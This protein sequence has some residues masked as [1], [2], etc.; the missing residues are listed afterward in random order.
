M[1]NDIDKVS[2]V[3][4]VY[5]VEVYIKQCV[6]SCLYQDHENIEILLI[7]DGSTDKSG[8]ICDELGKV[9]NKIR[10]FHKKNGGL[11]DARNYG[12]EHAI[13]EYITFVDADDII[14]RNLVSTLYKGVKEYKCDLAVCGFV[15]FIDNDVPQ[16]VYDGKYNC[17]DNENAIKE[18]LYQRSLSTSSCA[19]IYHKDLLR[20]NKFIKGQ[21]FEDNDFLFRIL[22]SCKKVC[23]NQSLLYA[24][25]HRVGSITTSNFSEKDF[26]I[27]EIGKRILEDSKCMSGKI[28]RAAIA[29]QTTNCLRVVLTISDNYLI[30]K[31]Y[32]YCENFINIHCREILKDSNVR[33]KVKVALIMRMIGIPRSIMLHIRNSGNRWN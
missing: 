16:Y 4:P 22:L 17:I 2:I 28:N 26:D 27:I 31:R 33:L 29:Y 5:N 12:I 14:G 15:H 32:L 18:F 20:E 1:S 6:E 21:R 19:K 30:D 3:I 8:V 24:Y 13:G 23:L 25:R 11:S 10:V 9:S 7:D